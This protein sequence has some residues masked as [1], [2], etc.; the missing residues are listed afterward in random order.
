MSDDVKSCPFCG[1]VPVIVDIPELHHP[2]R[3]DHWAVVCE[4]P[5]CP[6][7][8]LHVDGATREDAIANWNTRADQSEL[9]R[10]RAVEARPLTDAMVKAWAE[11]HDLTMCGSLTDLRGM[12]E[13]AQSIQDAPA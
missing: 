3:P 11:R 8:F 9:S 1:S 7:D 4:G 2:T 6:V 10:L 5:S 12:I 13:D